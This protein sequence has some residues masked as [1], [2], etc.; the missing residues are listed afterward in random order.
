MTQKFDPKELKNS[1]RIF[2]S[3]TPKYTWDWYLKW[4]SSILVLGAM[5][6]RGIPELQQ[7]DLILSILGITGW[8]GVSIAWKD[9]ALIMLN[10]VGLLFL[11]RNLITLWVQ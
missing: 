9:R 11:L 4:I 1:N 3:A 8:V 6:I 2:K 5:S 10:S 7:T